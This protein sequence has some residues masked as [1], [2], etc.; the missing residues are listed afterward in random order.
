MWDTAT[1]KDKMDAWLSG[2]NGSKIEV[3]ICNNDG[4]ALGAVESMKLLEKYY[5]HLVLTHYQKL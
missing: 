1:A 2:P 3:V 4:M 5:Q